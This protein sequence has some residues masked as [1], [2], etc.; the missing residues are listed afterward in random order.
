MASQPPFVRKA[1]ALLIIKHT[2]LHLRFMFII[3]VPNLLTHGQKRQNHAAL[4][5]KKKNP[6]RPA[7]TIKHCIVVLDLGKCV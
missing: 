3:L 7:D 4:G 1:C 6:L 2:R 5:K